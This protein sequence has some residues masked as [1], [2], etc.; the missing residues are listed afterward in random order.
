MQS[1]EITDDLL[2]VSS[3]LADSSSYDKTHSRL[4]HRNAWIAKNED[5]DPWIQVNFVLTV[6]IIEILTQGR[7]VYEQRTKNYKVVY[8]Q[9]TNSF[10]IYLDENGQEKV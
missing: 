3:V 1:E 9:D 5:V 8:A 4:W 6:T 7:S 2:S 10:V